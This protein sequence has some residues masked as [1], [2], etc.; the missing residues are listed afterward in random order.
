MPLLNYTTGID[1]DKT[2]G[3]IAR[4]LSLHGATS[5]L[6]EYD[7]EDGY[8]KSLSFRIE[9]GE[10]MIGFRLPC[11]WKPVL[12]ILENDSKVPPARATKDQAIKTA[13]RIIKVWIDAQ[14]ALVE[15]KMA[16]TEEIF[17][18]TYSSQYNGSQIIVRFFSCLLAVQ[19]QENLK[20]K[21]S[22]LAVQI[23]R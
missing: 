8:I 6:T 19:R 10:Q 11:D 1:P 3:E 12:E 5:I 21:L 7:K 22:H 16:K 23:K 9:V 14:M 15:T 2:A 4:C 17:E 20:R 18:Q 13:W